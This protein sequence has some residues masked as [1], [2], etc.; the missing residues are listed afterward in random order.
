MPDYTIDPDEYAEDECAFCGAMDDLVRGHVLNARRGGTTTIPMC[1][2]CNSSMRSNTFK[3]WIRGLQH[4]DH[5]KWH[6]ILEYQK[7]KRTEL[8]RVVRRIRR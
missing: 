7:W 4:N 6:D 2:S 1:R 3:G 5:G 8:A